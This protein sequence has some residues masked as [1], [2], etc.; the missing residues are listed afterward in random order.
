[1]AAAWVPVSVCCSSDLCEIRE[2]AGSAAFSHAALADGAGGH[3]YFVLKN[4]AP[5]RRLAP[6]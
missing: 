5:P 4:G 6:R 1:M 2:A 3:D